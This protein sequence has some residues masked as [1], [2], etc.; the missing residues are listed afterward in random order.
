MVAKRQADGEAMALSIGS[1]IFHVT[2]ADISLASGA[3]SNEGA[4]II[5]NGNAVVY[6]TSDKVMLEFTS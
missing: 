6:F 4:S 2:G 5:Y 1:R 3:R